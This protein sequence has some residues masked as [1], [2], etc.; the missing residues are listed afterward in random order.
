[1][2][3]IMRVRQKMKRALICLV[4]LAGCYGSGLAE[5][6]RAEVLGQLGEP[7]AAEE[8]ARRAAALEA[9]ARIRSEERHGWV[10]HDLAM[11]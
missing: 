7:A 10:W 2:G 9:T 1:M 5:Q 3:R 6:G 4:A 11:D 8:A